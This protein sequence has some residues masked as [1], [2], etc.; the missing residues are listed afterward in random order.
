MSQRFLI[1]K[2]AEDLRTG[3]LFVSCFGFIG[4]ELPEPRAVLEVIKGNDVTT[5]IFEDEEIDIVKGMRII[6]QDKTPMVDPLKE[7][8]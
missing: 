4:S 5:L 3:D 6:V 1:Y 2:G 7:G 8:E